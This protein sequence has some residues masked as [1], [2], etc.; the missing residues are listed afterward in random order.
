MRCEC[1][2]YILP[3]PC[4]VICMREKWCHE[5]WRT[6][7]INMH[8]EYNAS[9]YS[10]GRCGSF[11]P[12]LGHDRRVQVMAMIWE[13]QA[14]IQFE[15]HLLIW[16]MNS[17]WQ[18]R[19][20][21]SGQQEEYWAWCLLLGIFWSFCFLLLLAASSSSIVIHWTHGSLSRMTSTSF[22]D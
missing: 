8:A 18:K 9:V 10:L 4:D 19:S 7:N 12:R 15:K 2:L 1:Y 16:E 5:S 6:Q 22:A 3:R 11:G 13:S 20:S 21:G 14:N 17:H